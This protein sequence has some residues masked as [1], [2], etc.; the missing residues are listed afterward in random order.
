M[1]SWQ[2]RECRGLVT[3]DGSRD[4]GD[5]VLSV[6]APQNFR[7]SAFPSFRFSKSGLV[8]G[9]ACPVI[10]RSL[11]VSGAL[12]AFANAALAVGSYQQTRDGRTLVWNNYPKH[13]DEAAWS[14]R[15]D[16]DGRAQGFGTLTWYTKQRGFTQPVL[17]ARYW[18]KMVDGKL[19]GPVNVH[20]KKKTRHALFVDGARATRWSAGTASLIDTGKQRALIAQQ[21]QERQ[22]LERVDEPSVPAEGPLQKAE[23]Q[24]VKDEGGP[25]L[26]ITADK[27]QALEVGGQKS[28]VSG[29]SPEVR[30]WTD[31]A[32]EVSGWPKIEAD[33]SIRLV[34]LPPP[35]L[36]LRR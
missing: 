25:Q 33:Q 2:R 21:Q 5:Y 30:S 3:S 6:R 7:F 17:Y 8:N 10:R 36:K 18:G 20:V 26:Q 35:T 12:I 23:G 4:S 19:D 29:S 13:G 31:Q 22:R 1:N 27:E 16:R 11:L 28:D 34:A 15:R 24:R 14:G 32:P 9:R